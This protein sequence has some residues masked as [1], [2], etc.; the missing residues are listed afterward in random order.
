M[1]GC[2]GFTAE[3][4]AAARESLKEVLE[5]EAEA[6]LEAE[7]RLAAEEASNAS[8]RKTARARMFGRRV[9]DYRSDSFPFFFVLI[10]ASA[11]R[12]QSPRG[13]FRTFNFRILQP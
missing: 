7:R 9:P 10:K 3:D 2:G 8:S 13:R 1:N 6:V 4:I 11:L 5:A 12:Q